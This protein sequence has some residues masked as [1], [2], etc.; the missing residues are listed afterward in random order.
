MK[1]KNLVFVLII[2]GI[3]I[4][5]VIFR[6]VI[7]KEPKIEP[8]T[9]N[10]FKILSVSWNEERFNYPNGREG[11]D[12]WSEVC[13]YCL[14]GILGTSDYSWVSKEIRCEKGW[15]SLTLQSSKNLSVNISDE[16]LNYSPG[17]KFYLEGVSVNEVFIE[18]LAIDENHDIIFCASDSDASPFE[19]K[20]EICKSIT[21]EAKCP[22]S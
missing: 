3:V 9:E 16:K 15:F 4:L 11:L 22:L 13:D 19:D 18:N 12:E 20:N 21:L 1:N 2:V 8:L 5:V 10:D 17:Y 7:T 14:K 6:N